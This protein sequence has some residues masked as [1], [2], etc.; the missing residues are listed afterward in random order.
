MLSILK[1][2]INKK[3]TLRKM[4]T[5]VVLFMILISRILSNI[6]LIQDVHASFDQ[7]STRV[8]I[9][10]PYIEDQGEVS[11]EYLDSQQII[12]KYFSARTADNTSIRERAD[13]VEAF[14]NKWNSPMAEYAEFIVETAD[15]FGMDWRLIPAISIVESSGGIYCFKPYNAFGWGSASFK[16]FEH[17]IYTV[18]E[19]LALRY[20][21]DNPY[22]IAYAYCPP[23]A[24]GWANKVTN[25]MNQ[26]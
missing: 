16:S 9:S 7:D 13:K 4:V 18:S 5:S 17:S 14:Y 23:N 8:E 19:G 25:L 11:Q 20:G 12:S 1:N 6:T 3:G 26:M 22:V 10:M 24:L 2:R 15:H 21:S